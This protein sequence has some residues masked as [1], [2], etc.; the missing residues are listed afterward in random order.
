MLKQ[1]DITKLQNHFKS[2]KVDTLINESIELLKNNSK[3]VILLDILGS[4][5]ASIKNYSEATKYYKQALEINPKTVHLYNNLAN[6]Y[7]DEKNTIPLLLCYKNRLKL[8]LLI[9]R[10]FYN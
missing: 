10:V 9:L 1:E 2:G 3:S 5:Y 8:T 4:A 6:V 7:I